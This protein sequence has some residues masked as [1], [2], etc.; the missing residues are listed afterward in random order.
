M[1]LL[2]AVAV[3]TLT[4]SLGP[5]IAAD[6]PFGCEARVPNTCYFRIFYSP[7]GTRDVVLPA[8]MKVKIPGVQI[9]RDRYC[10]AV[11]ARPTNKCSRKIINANYNS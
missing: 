5:A 6:A 11:G 10:V 3:A 8:G 1:R 7:R 9:D 4:A 2:I